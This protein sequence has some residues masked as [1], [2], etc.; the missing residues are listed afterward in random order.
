MTDWFYRIE[1][2]G[3]LRSWQLWVIAIALSTF[4]YVWWPVKFGSIVLLLT[5]FFFLAGAGYLCTR[6]FFPMRYHDLAKTDSLRRTRALGVYIFLAG[7]AIGAG[8]GAIG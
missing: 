7:A 5:R 2:R 4:I 6:I 1:S 8:S 3:W